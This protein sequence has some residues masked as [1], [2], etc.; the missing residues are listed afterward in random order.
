MRLQINEFFFFVHVVLAFSPPFSLDDGKHIAASISLSGEMALSTLW[1][2]LPQQRLIDS[3]LCFFPLAV[4][5]EKEKHDPMTR[6]EA[7]V[8]IVIIV[9]ALIELDCN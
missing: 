1:T 3:E 2:H 9:T 4:L 7:K 8:N 5:D 6:G